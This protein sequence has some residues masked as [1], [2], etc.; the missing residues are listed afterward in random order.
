VRYEGKILSHGRVTG[1]K[2]FCKEIIYWIA[3]AELNLE[4]ENIA[5]RR[6]TF[7]MLIA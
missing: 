4:A 7:I 3:I 1:T 5:T 2:A 6:C